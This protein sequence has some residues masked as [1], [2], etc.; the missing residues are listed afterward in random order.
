MQI[1]YKAGRILH[2]DNAIGRDLIAS[3]AATEVKPTPKPVPNTSWEVRHNQGP[4]LSAHCATCG[5]NGACGGT[6]AGTMKFL[7]C[8]TVETPP[9]AV[10][11]NYEKQYRDWQNGKEDRPSSVRPAQRQIE[12]D[13]FEKLQKARTSSAGT[14]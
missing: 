3:G 7:H 6:T 9:P 12:R 11:K 10:A 13:R 5:L 14:R 4:Y 1:Q 8:L 2:V